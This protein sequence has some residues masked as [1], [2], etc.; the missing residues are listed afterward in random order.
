M[1][2]LEDFSGSIGQDFEVRFSDATLSLRLA[3]AEA[4]P[5][6]VREGG[7]FGL[8]F[9]GPQQPVL[10]QGTYTLHEG[11]RE[12]EIFIVPISSDPDG[13]RY[14]AIFS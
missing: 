11:E 14:E 3:V 4:R 8:E 10:A 12:L 1:L 13:T 7:A 9:V 2:T 5:H 6:G